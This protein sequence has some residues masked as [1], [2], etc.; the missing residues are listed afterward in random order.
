MGSFLVE[1]RRRNRKVYIVLDFRGRGRG[2][3][4]GRK[5]KKKGRT[6]FKKELNILDGNRKVRATKAR[7]KFTLSS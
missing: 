1:A 3:G 5:R 7:E 4:R 6:K 2:R